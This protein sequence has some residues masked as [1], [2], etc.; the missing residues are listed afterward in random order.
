MKSIVLLAG[1]FFGLLVVSGMRSQ[2]SSVQPP[3]PYSPE[4]PPILTVLSR[5]KTSTL[6][7]DILRL[8]TIR[9]TDIEAGYVSFLVPRDSTC[10]GADRAYLNGLLNR[11][12]SSRYIYDHAFEGQ[13]AIYRENE[14]LV[15]VNYFP[16]GGDL[17]GRVSIDEGHPFD[18]K[19][20]SGKS[21]LI[22]VRDGV[23]YVG[24]KSVVL[25]NLNEGDGG[26]IDVDECAVF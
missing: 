24:E 19:L 22:S 2:A 18:M 23:I 1:T 13:L 16:R 6:F 25:S 14:Q 3:S 8:S 11:A 5:S 10:S 21:V 4:T 7:A 9:R 12:S 20:L 17:D 26:E 15:S